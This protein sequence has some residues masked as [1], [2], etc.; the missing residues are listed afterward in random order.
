MG[1]GGR[2]QDRGRGILQDRGVRGIPQ[3]REDRGIPQDGEVGIRGDTPG[4]GGILEG[5][6][7]DGGGGY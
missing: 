5:I 7:K 2:H 6:P 1:A 4:W 3:G